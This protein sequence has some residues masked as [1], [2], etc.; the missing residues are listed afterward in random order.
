MQ[1][2][3]LSMQMLQAEQPNYAI[4]TKQLETHQA[5]AGDIMQHNE[6][7]VQELADQLQAKKTIYLIDVRQPEE[8]QAFN[9]GGVLIP[10]TSLAEHLDTIPKDASIVVY[11]RSGQRSHK[12]Q[13]FLSKAG[14]A[15]VRNLRGGVLAWQHEMGGEAPL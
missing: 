15:H 3:D 10:L 9:I 5:V 8:H 4:K 12:A 11:C 2:D 13:E 7:T 6:I 1:L 14:F